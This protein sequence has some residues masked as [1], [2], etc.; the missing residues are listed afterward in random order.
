M[1][2]HRDEDGDAKG[3]ETLD[4]STVFFPGMMINDSRVES[5]ASKN[6]RPIGRRDFPC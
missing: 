2:E 3:H 6:D 1:K 4:L 5:T